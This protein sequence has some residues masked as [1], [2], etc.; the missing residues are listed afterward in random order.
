MLDDVRFVSQ[1][2]A[3]LFKPNRQTVVVSITDNSGA[4]ARPNFAGFRD[5]LPL[6]FIDVSEECVGALPGC[7][8]LQPTPAQHETISGLHGEEVPTLQHAQAI[9]SFLHRHHAS[10]TRIKVLVHCFAGA[11]RSAAVAQWVARQF[12]V[13][14]RDPLKRGTRDANPRVTRLLETA[15]QLN[16]GA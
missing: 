2:A 15:Q 13:P 6:N 8:P 4:S 9:G 7:W 10:S 14:L 3:R 1:E 5:V 12:E 11:S 16:S